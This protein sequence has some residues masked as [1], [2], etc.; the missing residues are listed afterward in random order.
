MKTF[1]Y[2]NIKPC[3][4][5][6]ILFYIKKY[7]II[8]IGQCDITL[9]RPIINGLPQKCRCYHSN[10]LSPQPRPLLQHC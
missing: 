4:D 6:I 1:T 2:E 10:V 7:N 8:I 3:K 9:S 5:N